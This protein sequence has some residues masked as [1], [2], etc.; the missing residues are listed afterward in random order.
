MM[1]CHVDRTMDRPYCGKILNQNYSENLKHRVSECISHFFLFEKT[2]NPSIPYIAAWR[3]GEK[4]IWYEYTSQKFMDL[5][6]CNGQELA[7]TFRNAVIDRRIYRYPEMDSGIIEEI[8]PKSELVQYR[9]ELREEGKNSGTVEAV[10][11]ISL[12]PDNLVWLKDQALVETY[13]ED[14]ICLSL[15]CLTVVSKEMAAEDKLKK[16]RDLLEEIVKERTAELT[17]TNEQLTQEIKERQAAEKRLQQSN[18]VLQKTMNGVIQAMSVTVEQRDPYTAGHQKRATNLAVSIATEMGL[19]EDR[20]KGIEMA[21]LIHDIG[22]ISIPVGIL[23]KPGRLNSAEFEL[24]RRHPVVAY[25]ILREID[26][27]WPVD[28]IVL[29][30]HERVNGSGYPLGISGD[31]TFLEARILAVA[32]VVETVASHRPY[33]PGLGL[34]MALSEIKENRGTLFDPVPVDACLML[35]EENRFQFV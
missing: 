8:L 1:T 2:G 16:H 26:F 11:K 10:Y 34:D 4:R 3:E 12:N 6:G 25:E 14:G 17:K 23:S 5:M 15:G 28:T 19:S 7:E 18:Q 35:F 27:P 29:Q 32:D 9:E 31:E 20:I 22:K 13:P 21:G 30:H 33:R 24:I